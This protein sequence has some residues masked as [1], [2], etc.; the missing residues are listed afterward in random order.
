MWNL[1]LE[2]P[3]AKFNHSSIVTCICFYP[4]QE[5]ET[6]EDEKFVSG[7]LDKYIRIWSITKNNHRVVDY[8]NIKEYITAIAYFPTGDMI[9]IGT[10]NG[11]CSVYDTKVI[12]FIINFYLFIAKIKIQLF[13]HL[14]K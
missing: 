2:V 3:A 7:C 6:D 10:H 4:V 8:T 1:D 9:V 14:Q 12:F 13:I 5:N 11:R